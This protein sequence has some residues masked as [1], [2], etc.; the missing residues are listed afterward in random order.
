MKWLWSETI[1]RKV[2]LL[3]K[4]KKKKKKKVP[5]LSSLSLVRLMGTQA[6]NNEKL[7]HEYN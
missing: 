6:S 2:F 5:T 4:K 1:A 3:K 7:Q